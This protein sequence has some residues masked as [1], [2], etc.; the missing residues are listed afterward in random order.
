VGV[1]DINGDAVTITTDSN[2]KALLIGRYVT[3]GWSLKYDTQYYLKEIQAPE[4][5]QLSK[6][7]VAFKLTEGTSNS[8]S[9][10]YA[11]ADTVSIANSKVKKEDPTPTDPSDDKKV[12]ED[13]TTTNDPGTTATSTGSTVTA[14]GQDEVFFNL[15]PLGSLNNDEGAVLGARRGAETSDDNNIAARIMIII[16]AAAAISIILLR[17]KHSDASI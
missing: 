2:G 7:L 6:E 17:K 16:A 12:T 3:D 9:K 15:V 11:V 8:V 14:S 4:G 5:Y 10:I 1:T 13:D